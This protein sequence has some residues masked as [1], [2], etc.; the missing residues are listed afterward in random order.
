[1]QQFLGRP[2]GK[3]GI[4]SSDNPKDMD[5]MIGLENKVVAWATSLGLG[6]KR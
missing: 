3:I 1:M 4:Y 6:K 2:D 5:S